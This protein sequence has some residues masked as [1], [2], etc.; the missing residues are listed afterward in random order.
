MNGAI[1][2]LGKYSSDSNLALNEY[3]TKWMLLSTKQ[4]ARVHSLQTESVNISGN[5][6]SLE[7]VTR[8]KLL[9]VYKHEHLTWD[10]HIN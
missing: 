9:G 10:V 4:M 7:R 8:T 5:G 2:R 6:E 3:K 1:S